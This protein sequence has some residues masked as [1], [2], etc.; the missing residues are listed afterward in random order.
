MDALL[1]LIAPV[2]CVCCGKSS[3]LCCPEHLTEPGVVALSGV[4]MHYLTP[5]DDDRLRTMIAFKDKGVTALAALYA[6]ATRSYLEAQGFTDVV[7]VVPP[8]NPRNYRTRGFHPALLV[9]NKLGLRVRSA[10][11]LKR[12]ADQRTLSALDRAQNLSGA[13]ELSSLAGESVLL[14]D[15]VMTTGATLRELHRA[16]TEAGGEVVAGCVL[17][18]RFQEF[19]PTDLK[20]A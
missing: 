2:K 4:P 18:M 5:L 14:F 19:V 12:L 8:R 10:R 6:K 20:K 15:D 16:A 11:A 17:A 1:Q 3:V 7:V 13:Y 9:A